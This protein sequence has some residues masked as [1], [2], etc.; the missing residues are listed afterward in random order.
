MPLPPLPTNKSDTWEMG[1]AFEK[2][3]YIA[4]V[5]AHAGRVLVGGAGLYQLRAGDQN[6][7]WRELP[8]TIGGVWKVAQEPR[9]PFRQAVSSELGVAVFLGKEGGGRIAHVRPVDREVS[10]TNLVWGRHGQRFVLYVLWSNGEVVRLDP[11][12]GTRE[13]LDL[14]AAVALAADSYG[15]VALLTG[16]GPKVYVTDDGEKFLFRRLEVTQEWLDALP[17]D[18]PS[19][20]AVA[21][22]AV[23]LSLGWSGAFVSRDVDALPF[24]K[25]EPL[26]CAGPLVFEGTSADAALFGAVY[27]EALTA[28]VRVD[29]SGR[30][31]RVGD[32]LVESGPASPF[33][34]IAWDAARRR[35]FAVH[36]QAGLVVATAPDAKGKKLVAPN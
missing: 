15:V 29:A 4:S 7:Q 3:G 2:K 35:L 10:V 5:S 24:V 23:A 36:R 1:P 11:E 21:G 19:H 28:I 25:S 22:K 31:V 16:E 26:A 8:P 18:E 9:A 32:L 17:P 13:T 30:A 33:D 6:W 27:T 14:S 20:L 34:E 12:S